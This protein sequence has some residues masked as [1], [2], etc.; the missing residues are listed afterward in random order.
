MK[1]SGTWLCEYTYGSEGYE[2]SGI[3]GTSVPFTMSLTEGWLRNVSGYV[4]DD[5]SR[6]GQPERGRIRGRRR[7]RVLEFLKIM[8][9]HHVVDETGKMVEMRS[10]YRDRHGLEL[11]ADLPPHRI[12]YRGTI[13]ETGEAIAG[14]WQIVPWGR[15]AHGR[16]VSMGAGTWSARRTSDLASE[17]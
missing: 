3:A 13:D 11:P 9:V 7:G 2:Q 15:T 14:E 5:A 4:R 6:G 10:F 1:V 12:A 17:V 8:P 16:P